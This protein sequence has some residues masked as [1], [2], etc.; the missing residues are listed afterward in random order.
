MNNKS[1]SSDN[2]KNLCKKSSLA[3]VLLQGAGNGRKYTQVSE[4]SPYSKQN[5]PTGQSHETN[6]PMGI[7][8]LNNFHDYKITFILF[9]CVAYKARLFS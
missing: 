2:L 6:L 4:L 3:V 5:V 7:V 8:N 1:K 9:P